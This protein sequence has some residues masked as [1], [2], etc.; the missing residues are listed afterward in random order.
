MNL[1]TSSAFL[2]RWTTSSLPE[3]AIGVARQKLALGRVFEARPGENVVD[4]FGELA[5]RVGV[6]GGVHQDVVAEEVVDIIEHILPLVVFDAAEKPAAGH[7]F[8][9]LLLERGGAADIDRLLVH[10]SAPDGHPTEAAFE[11][12]HSEAREPVE[13]PA[14]DKR[15]DKPH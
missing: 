2:P 1:S 11:H 8:A 4:R 5:F 7:V 9:G 10:A 6:V 3:E 14:A 15:S 12:A 13:Q